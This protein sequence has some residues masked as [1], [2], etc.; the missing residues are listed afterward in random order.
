MSDTLRDKM[1]I[2]QIVNLVDGKKYIG[3]SNN[4]R[5]RKRTH[6]SNLRNNNHYNYYLQRAFNKHGEDN[7]SFEVIEL[8][9]TIEE[10]LPREQYY[11]EL[12]QVCNRDK[13][14]NLIVDAV[15]GK[16]SLE[17]RIKMSKNHAD[18]SG[19][20]NPNYGKK[21]KLNHNYGKP[22]SEETKRKISLANKGRIHSE[23]AKLK[24]SLA[25]KGSNHPNYNKHHSEKTKLKMSLAH[26]GSKNPMYGKAGALSP[27]FK[28]IICV[29][30]G[31][32]YNGI[33]EASRVLNI[34]RTSISSCC[35]G[36]TK[37][38][39]GYHWRYYEG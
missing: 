6:F 7:F 26:K 18:V 2:Y 31:T 37:T 12:Y 36:K 38:A 9:N 24:M 35:R 30:T 32:I 16:T 28:K 8:V 13:G 39:G 34:C 33:T 21:G 23:E 1:G 25:K 10:L 27:T 3:S 17:T 15:R 14:Y 20:K 19:S 29:E 11:I 5:V 22:R 4:L